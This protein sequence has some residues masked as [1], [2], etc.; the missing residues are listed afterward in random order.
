MFVSFHSHHLFLS[1]VEAT[2]QQPEALGFLNIANWRLEPDPYAYNILV[3]GDCVTVDHI[4]DLGWFVEVVESLQVLNF[5][6]EEVI[7]LYNT[8]AA[9]LHMGQI[10][11]LEPTGND[12]GAELEEKCEPLTIAAELMQVDAGMLRRGF[13]LKEIQ[14]HKQLIEKRLKPHEAYAQVEALSKALYGCLFSWIIKKINLTLQTRDELFCM[15]I[16]VLDIFGF[17]CFDDSIEL[18]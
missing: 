1:V 8:I 11:F 6:E 2:R 16:G 17:E 18:C 13:L 5:S 12:E 3:G 4:D 7:S 10:E 15:K 9:I 14:V